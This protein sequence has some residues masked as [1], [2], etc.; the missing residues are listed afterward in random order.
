[1]T[2]PGPQHPEKVLRDDERRRRQKR[3]KHGHWSEYI[4]AAVLRFKG[5]RILARRFRSGS[6]EIDLIVSRGRRVAFVEVK[7]RRSFEEAEVSISDKQRQRIRNAADV[8][9]ARHPPD[10]T[11]DICFDVLFVV[12]WHLPRHIENV[13]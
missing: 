13:L 3:H 5:Y 6:G 8:W 7:Q 12:P 10:I 9:L 1:M 2:A 4:A 11:H